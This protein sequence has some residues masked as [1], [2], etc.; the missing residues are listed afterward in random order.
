MGLKEELTDA[1]KTA[2]KSGDTA[3]KNTIRMVMSAIKYAEVQS[4]GSVSEPDILGILQKEIKSRQDTIA[5]A[6]KI[7]RQDLIDAANEEIA[8]IQDFLPK[9]LTEEELRAIIQEAISET[10]AA[11]PRDMGNV[12][13]VLMPKVKGKADGKLVS[14]L[15]QSLLQGS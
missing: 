9:Q 7:N 4:G 15:V 13:K 8:I 5:D 14:S 1:M 12:M 2:M 6:E 10:G 11:S 3:R